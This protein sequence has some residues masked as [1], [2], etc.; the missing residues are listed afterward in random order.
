MYNNQKR[1]ITAKLRIKEK[2]YYAVFYCPN[3]VGQPKEVWRTLNLEVKAGNKR[4]AIDRMEK[5]KKGQRD[6]YL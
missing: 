2:R 3:K 4:N 6:F 5:M 1:A